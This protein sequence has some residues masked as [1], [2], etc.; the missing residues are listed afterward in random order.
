MTIALSLKREF[1]KRLLTGEGRCRRR[2]AIFSPGDSKAM[3][4]VPNVIP[5]MEAKAPPSEWPTIQ[6]F[7][8]GY[9]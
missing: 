7:E 3:T 2:E 1:C 6:I 4:G 8:S 9:M 5:S